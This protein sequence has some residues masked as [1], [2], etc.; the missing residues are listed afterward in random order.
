MQ[1]VEPV[2][3]RLGV[4]L[5]LVPA[6]TVEEFDGAFST[7]MRE[8]MGG[9][10]VIASPLSFSQRVPLAEL[11]LKCRLVARPTEGFHCSCLGLRSHQS[12]LSSPPIEAGFPKQKA[13][14]SNEHGPAW[15]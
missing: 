3:K 10:L 6:R 5:L 14:E 11:A 8:Q 15:L 2:G 4:Q 12:G 9:F 1:A 13:P 7:M